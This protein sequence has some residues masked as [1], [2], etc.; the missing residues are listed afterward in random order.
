M[1]QDIM[2]WLNSQPAWI[3]EASNLFIKQGK[4]EDSQ[5]T[6][7]TNICISEAKGA[8][9]SKYIIE[10]SNLLSLSM[11]EEFA[12]EKISDIKGVNAISSDKPME[13]GKTGIN[14]VY[15]TNGTGKSGYIR[16]LKMISGATYREDIKANIYEKKREIPKCNV[17]IAIGDETQQFRCDLS[18]AGQYDILR[19]IDIFDTKTAQGY[20][21][22]EKEAS[23]EPWI[24][25]LFSVLGDAAMKIK[26]EL[27]KRKE[28]VQIQKYDIPVELLEVQSIRDLEHITYKSKVADVVSE[29]TEQDE[30]NLE[31]L[32]SKSQI[33][34]NNLSIQIKERNIE[35]LTEILEYFK[36]FEEF[37]SDE[38]IKKIKLLAQDWNDK[39]EAYR[40][41][42]DLLETNIDE[43]D[44]ENKRN[45][46]WVILWKTARKLFDET[47]LEDDIDFVDIGGQCPLCH[48]I[49]KNEN[50]LRM[51]S[52]DEYVNGEVASAENQAKKRYVESLIYPEVKQTEKLLTRISDYKD[53]LEKII[54]NTNQN[55][56][57][58]GLIINSIKDEPIEIKLVNIRDVI[59]LLE[60]IIRRIQKEKE[61]LIKIN[62]AEDQKNIQKSIL[63]LKAKKT[64]A[65]N[66]R[67]IEGNINKL[68]SIH[69]F[70]EAIKKTSTNKITSKSKELARLLI[71][72]AYIN[73][74]NQ[75]LRKLSAS[76]LTA[77]V[78]E[79]KGRKGKIPYKVQLCDADGNYISPRDILSEGESRAVA[80]AAFFA[81]ASGREE[82]CPLIVD[83]PVS[84][85]DYEYEGRVIERLVEVAQHRQVIVFTHRISVVVGINE[86]ISNYSNVPFKELSLK[87]TKDRKGI[88]GEPDVNA[89]KSDKLLNKLIND[90]LSKLK[91]MD[92]LDDGVN[93]ERHYICQ[94]FRNCVEKSVEEFLIGEVVVRFRKDVQTRRIKYLP[95]ITQDDCDIIDGMMTK[96]SA[97][98]H[99]M[100]N[101]TPLI[102]F[103]IDE[104]EKDMIKFA[105]WIKGRKKKL[106]S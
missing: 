39:K 76:G 51:H 7:L 82:N 63:E 55:L 85:L 86:K 105:N 88:P 93:K 46:A 13:F 100:S 43:V 64:I 48:Q 15:G 6:Q 89:G 20:I 47:K 17:N 12:I 56:M 21:G 28:A 60:S 1:E 4:I 78:I 16:I 87:A 41:A 52:I 26:V 40:L 44:K 57:E 25:E 68:D 99:S 71:T 37:Y 62:T 79:G 84:S 66:A 14:V 91:K 80:L 103:S 67:I 77:Q 74:F 2:R 36:C 38:H 70:D 32:K 83:D 50:V 31:E 10:Q 94:Q 5:I 96:Y 34:K 42:Q 104:I 27:T 106:N 98:D 58:L 54:K 8:D 35:E 11:G 61:E 97:Y 75:E 92:E 53:E 72:D 101:E 18:K 90:N 23:F 73:R 3:R 24:F 102:E 59:K 45:P 95:S 33:D 29:M 9:C 19:K 22:D 69:I 30:A 65:L 81:E 49:V